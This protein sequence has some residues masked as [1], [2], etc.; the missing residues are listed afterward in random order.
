MTSMRDAPTN[1]HA[2]EALRFRR[3]F[4]LLLVAGISV[5]F[6]VMVRPFVL[7]VFLAAIFAGMLYPLYRW[8]LRRLWRRRGLAASVTLV[9]LLL[10]IGLPVAAFLT[11]VA[12]EAAEVGQSAGTWLA[13]QHGRLEELRSWVERVPLVSRL[14]PERGQLAEQLREAARRTGPF[15]MGTLSAATRG[16]VNFFLQVFV[17][18]Y[19]IFFF[20]VGGPG[21]LQRILDYLPLTPDEKTLLLERFVSVTRATLKGSLLIGAI[22]GALAGLAFWAAGIPAPA[23]WATVMTVLAL[24]PAVG[25]G[26]IWIPTVLYLFVAGKTIAAVGLLLWCAAVVSTIDNVLRPRLVGRDAQMP[27]LLILLSTLGGLI[28]FGAVG[29]IVGPIVAAVFSTVWTLYGQAF[30][31]WLPQ[32]PAAGRAGTGSAK[33][34]AA[35]RGAREP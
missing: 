8:L 22:Q 19:A 21:L 12:T 5:L 25:A 35:E 31:D 1:D 3:A 28:L 27:T 17:F 14:L 32:A 7:T 10:G 23:F 18:L 13:E 26:L 2:A 33:E 24:I 34:G 16:T 4:L 15:L 11:M 20:L 9:L 30:R 29:F 6:L